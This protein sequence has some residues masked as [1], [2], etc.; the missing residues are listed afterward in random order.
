[1]QRKPKFG[2]KGYKTAGNGISKYIVTNHKGLIEAK[3]GFQF[4][5]LMNKLCIEF[6][7]Y[8]NLPHK[9][10]GD[11]TSQD[12]NFNQVQENFKLFKQYL[13]QN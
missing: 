4:F 5:S 2:Y 9:D 6:L 12:Y 7:K 8:N 13:C 10:K 11:F 1:M 3:D